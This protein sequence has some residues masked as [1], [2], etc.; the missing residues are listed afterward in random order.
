[1]VC[2]FTCGLQTLYQFWEDGGEDKIK[3]EY[4]ILLAPFVTLHTKKTMTSKHRESWLR[5]NMTSNS[6]ENRAVNRV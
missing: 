5:N 4:R 1:M 2:F 6:I 3:Y